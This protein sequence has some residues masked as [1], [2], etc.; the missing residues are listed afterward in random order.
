VA[1]LCAAA[2]QRG[3][4]TL[5][6]GAQTFGS[7]AVNLHAMGCDFYTGSSHKWFMGP[8]ET[9]VL[10]VRRERAAAL[11][12]NV[13]GL[14][15]D[16]AR[17]RG[18]RKFETFGQRDDAAV[19]A[20]GRA[21]EFHNAVGRERVEARV[22]ELAAR[23]KTRLRERVAGVTFATP[24][25]PALSGGIVIF[26]RPGLD[27]GAASRALYEKAQITCAGAAGNSLRFAP[28]VY[29]LLADVEKAVDAVAAL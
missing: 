7:L 18:A 4:L 27:T 11:W 8:R 25:D 3:V 16:G 13:V 5:V 2:R 17:E 24:A 22:R 19:A 29:V 23:F 21:V 20:V 6:D 15:W 1:E 26:T 14:G 9:G 12:P 10:Y 28:H